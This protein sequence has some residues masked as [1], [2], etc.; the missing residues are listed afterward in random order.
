MT[1]TEIVAIVALVGYAVYKQTQVAEVEDKG[2]F[3]MAIIYAIVG[4]AVGGFTVP[5]SETAVVL[6]VVSILLSV[7]VGVARGQLTRVWSEV[8]G[9]VMRQGTV[10]TVGLFLGMVAVK[11]G[12]GAYAYMHHIPGTGG[13]GEIMLM[14]AIMVAVQAELIRKRAAALKPAPQRADYFVV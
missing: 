3:K 10:L 9:R 11:F 1:P 8:D 6:V 14:M 13:F 2:R 5:R 12:M 7:V 4:I